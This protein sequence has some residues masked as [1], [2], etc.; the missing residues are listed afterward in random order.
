MAGQPSEQQVRDQVPSR[1]LSQGFQDML[2][3]MISDPA[4]RKQMGDNPEQAIQGAG[5]QLS[6][7]ETERLRAMTPEDRQK[8][9]R[10]MDTR[11]SKAW[12]YFVWNWFSWW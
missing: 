4:F 12:W 7:Q 10:E 8:L 5:I 1:E 3:R 9:F 2:G 11:D 6:P